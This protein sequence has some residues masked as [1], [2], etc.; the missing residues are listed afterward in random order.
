MVTILRIMHIK[1][2]KMEQITWAPSFS[3]GNEKLDEQ[4]KRL[5]QIINRLIVESQAVIKSEAVSDLLSE[6]MNYAQEHFTTE[7]ELLRQH[8]YPH[9]E[10]HI[11]EHQAFQDKIVDFRSAIMLNVEDIPESM[12]QYLRNWLMEHILK[13]D[14][15]YKFFFLEQKLK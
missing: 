12:L 2:Y 7:E 14:M 4:H 15:A 1:E 6:M 11:A 10:E 8:S 5:I 3:V 9:L 13:S